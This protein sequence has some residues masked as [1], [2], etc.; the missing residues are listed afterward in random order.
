MHVEDGMYIKISCADHFSLDPKP[1][2][3]C[4]R[5]DTVTT[6]ICLLCGATVQCK[7]HSKVKRRFYSRLY[8]S[9]CIWKLTK[10]S[11][12]GFRLR[13][14]SQRSWKCKIA[15]KLQIHLLSSLA[16]IGPRKKK[17]PY[18]KVHVIIL[19]WDL[20]T[21]YWAIRDRHSLKRYN[22]VTVQE[23]RILTRRYLVWISLAYYYCMN[24]Y[25]CDRSCIK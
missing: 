23:S 7:C 20:F 4:V 8:S 16:N 19:P 6:E 9:E 22:S 2:G 24:I 17:N 15:Y 1:I 21:V 12:G 5:T 13:F 14:P 18:T 25:A 11:W 10:L 3:E